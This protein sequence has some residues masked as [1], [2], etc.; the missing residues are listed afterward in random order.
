MLKWLSFL[1]LYR[2]TL[3]ASFKV[4]ANYFVRNVKS[5]CGIKS[6]SSDIDGQLTRWLKIA[7]ILKQLLDIVKI[8]ATNANASCGL[9]VGHLD[10]PHSTVVIRMFGK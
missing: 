4:A 3:S 1:L 7:K 5:S 2:D 6:T 9:K 8:A 10:K